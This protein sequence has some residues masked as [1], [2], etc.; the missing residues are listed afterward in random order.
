MIYLGSIPVITA[1]LLL[2]KN[3]YINVV[4][5]KMLRNGDKSAPV[6]S[7]FVIQSG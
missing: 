6:S 3:D 7:V 4:V 5:M 1:E 2:Y